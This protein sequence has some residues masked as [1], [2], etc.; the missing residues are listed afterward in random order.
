V[1]EGSAARGWTRRACLGAL[2]GL[3]LAGSMADGTMNLAISQNLA[4]DANISDARA[5][6]Q[7][8]MNWACRENNMSVRLVPGV[9]IQSAQLLQMI[10][11]AQVDAF[12]LDVM[13]YRQVVEFVEQKYMIS[14]DFGPAGGEEYV[15]LI[16]QDAD[17]KSLADLRGKRMLRLQAPTTRLAEEWLLLTQSRAG[18]PPDLSF[19][20][21]AGFDTKISRVI[22]PVFFRQADA[23]V[24]TRAG[25][26][27]MCELNPQVGQKL[28]VLANSPKLLTGGYFFHKNCS[29]QMRDKMLAAFSSLHKVNYGQ[30]V[31]TLFQSPKLGVKDISVLQ[32][33]LEL[34]R[35][36]ERARHGAPRKGAGQ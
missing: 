35:E 20:G 11:Q 30:Q 1:A 31:L 21:S 13:E 22:L 8:W 24:A 32:P 2:A 19:W 4:P 17:I 25:Y 16:R 14:A 10:R 29:P 23:A 26:Q 6:M 27:T 36:F 15:L 9:F 34:L 5:S 12:A 3:P 28:R 33:A 18:L 7:I